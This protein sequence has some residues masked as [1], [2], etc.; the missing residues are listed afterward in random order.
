MVRCVP[1]ASSN[2]RLPVCLAGAVHRSHG[3][4]GDQHVA[5]SFGMLLDDS[6]VWSSTTT[7]AVFQLFV[8]RLV[9]AMRPILQPSVLSSHTSVWMHMPTG[10]SEGCHV[11]PLAPMI[12]ALCPRSRLLMR[13][14]W[15][16]GPGSAREVGASTHSTLIPRPREL[17]FSCAHESRVSTLTRLARHPANKLTHLVCVVCVMCS[18]RRRSQP[19]RRTLLSRAD[20]VGRGRHYEASQAARSHRARSRFAHPR[21]CLHP[22]CPAVLSIRFFIRSLSGDCPGTIRSLSGTI[23]SLSEAYPELIWGLSGAYRGLS[24]AYPELIRSLSGAYRGTIRSLSGGGPGDCLMYPGRIRD[25]PGWGYVF[26]G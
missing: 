12:G 24:G 17:R 11:R 25:N 23:R 6:G 14:Q 10:C 21:L 22:A 19:S 9:P 4:G 26:G 5:T 15:L 1:R 7:R 16:C 18:D 3:T 13:T 20:G 8:A 2:G